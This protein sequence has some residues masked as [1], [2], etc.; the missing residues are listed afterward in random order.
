MVKDILQEGE[1]TSAPVLQSQ[2]EQNCYQ[3]AFKEP[4]NTNLQQVH[5]VSHFIR[6]IEQNVL[7]NVHQLWDMR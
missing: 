5:F 4:Y 6:N 1:I 3:Q 7:P 2:V